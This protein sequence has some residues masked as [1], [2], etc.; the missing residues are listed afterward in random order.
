M[1]KFKVKETPVEKLLRQMR[2][3]RKREQE[4]AEKKQRKAAVDARVKKLNQEKRERA[5]ALKTERN[6]RKEMFKTIM[7]EVE[8]EKRRNDQKVPR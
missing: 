2:D 7:T 4:K 6:I 8:K 5:H 1:G 3:K